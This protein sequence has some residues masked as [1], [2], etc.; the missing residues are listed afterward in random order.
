MRIKSLSFKSFFDRI[1]DN[2]LFLLIL[3]SLSL[4]LS[5]SIG[6]KK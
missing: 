2:I 6:T 1:L 3:R 4:S 5:L